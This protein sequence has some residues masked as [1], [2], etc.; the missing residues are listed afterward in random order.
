MQK[1]KTKGE[2][3]LQ[4]SIRTR[5]TDKKYQEILALVKQT[6]DESLSGAVR[7]ILMNKPIR[8]QVH[9]ETTSL[10]LEE[11]A[12]TRSEIRAIGVNINQITRYFNSYPEDDRKQFYAKVG[13]TKF[14]LME[15][16]VD[17]LSE[18]ISELC[19]KWLSV[20]KQEKES[21]GR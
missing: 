5:V 2:K 4:R 6:K 1:G 19:A 11:L 3:G 18:R 21:R 16:K 15:K 13:L 10:L 8:I 7:K 20:S 14:I 12:A 9:D 17:W